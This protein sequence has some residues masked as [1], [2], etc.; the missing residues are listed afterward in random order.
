[1]LGK[2]ISH[3][4][5]SL[6]RRGRGPERGSSRPNVVW[7]CADDFTPDVC[8]AYGNRMVRTPC[9][10]GLASQ[11]IRFDRA[12]STCPLS[13]PSR[14][15]FWTG[16]YP[17]RIGVTLSRTPLPD[18]EVTL[19]VLLRQAGYE[20]AAFGKTHYY[21]PRRHEFDVYVDWS[22]Y[23]AWLSKK[24]PVLPHSDGDMLGPWQPFA[25]PGRVWLNSD[26]LPYAAVDADMFG[27]FLASQAAQY[28]AVPKARPFFLYVGFY[29]THAPFWFPVEYRGRYSPR[30]FDV[31]AVGP[32]D[33]RCLPAVFRELTE[34]DKQG[35]MAAYATS[36]EYLDKNVGQ[37]LAALDRSTHA[38]N[39][40]VIF[41][42]DHGY[43]LGQ[44]GRFEKH[45]CYEPAVR[46]ALLMRFPG[47]IR[48]GRATAALVELIDLAPTILELCGVPTPA[49]LDGRRLTSLL[50]DRTDAHRVR[51][52]AEYADNEEAMIRT[53]HWKLIY[54]TGA[55][56][57]RDGYALGPAV[58]QPFVQLYNLDNDPEET[59]NLAG[60][61]EHAGRVKQ[62]TNE[63][64]DHLV[65]TARQPRLIPKSQD[66]RLILAHCLTPRDIDL[67][68]FIGNSIV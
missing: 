28:L 21:W 50:R 67:S 10:D 64:A 2:W 18:D 53:E 38:N 36:A 24:G 54:S 26:C 63:L 46:A 42:S 44:H 12:F 6:R 39:T 40:L 33:Y 7:I 1:M 62:L 16:R 3:L 58:G 45:C 47:L 57:R 8:G 31:P 41:T 20:V 34:A 48:P 68:S 9:L 32:E 15:S 51:V 59:I 13:T 23:E 65:R 49:N 37:V 17:R 11:G 61:A 22:E 29:E 4:A 30:S 25:D 55:R 56:R 35:I 14:Q 43:L 52:I 66:I 60:H 27:T 19:P 5:A